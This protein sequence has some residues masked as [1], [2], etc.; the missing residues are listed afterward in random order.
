MG[1]GRRPYP[2]A[3]VHFPVDHIR[4]RESRGVDA[5]PGENCLFHGAD[6]WDGARSLRRHLLARR[7]AYGTTW[8]CGESFEFAF[9]SAAPS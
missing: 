9:D 7:L 3:D 4:D 8:D 5:E 6:A 2:F 1:E